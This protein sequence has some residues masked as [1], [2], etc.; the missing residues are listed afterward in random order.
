M[1]P[2]T[3]TP[4]ADTPA[5]DTTATGIPAGYRAYR[6]VVA[7]SFGNWYG[8]GRDS[9]TGAETNDQVTRFALAQAPVATRPGRRRILDVGCGRG[10]QTTE[11]AEGLDAHATGLDLLDV[12]DVP[13]PARGEVRFRQGDFLEVA[14]S[15]LDLV[16]D[17]G[18][19]HHQRRADWPVWAA[20][21]AGLLRPGGV[22]VV[23]VFLS[24]D[25]EIAELPLADGRLNWWLTEQA[26]TDLYTGAGL[27]PADRLVID[28]NFRYQG[29][30]LEYLAL[31][32]RR[33]DG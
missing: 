10:R 23:S 3:D 16:V 12:W 7:D 8:E 25:G 5:T 30:W 9:W 21:G 33:T 6:R 24:P 18:C 4:A 29:H 14:E 32:F 17:N 26:V 20:H 13:P 31:S 22:L 2:T 27:T 15:G 28:R 1:P 19:L 11:L